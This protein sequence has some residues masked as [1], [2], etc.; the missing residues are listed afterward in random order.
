MCKQTK[1]TKRQILSI[2]TTTITTTNNITTPTTNLHDH[3]ISQDKD[4]PPP[5]PKKFLT[6]LKSSGCS[7]CFLFS[8]NSKRRER[9]KERDNKK[10]SRENAKIWDR[11]KRI[12]LI[13]LLVCFFLNPKNGDVMRLIRSVVL[14]LF[15]YLFFIFLL[16]FRRVRRDE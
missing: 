8:R 10:E 14:A 1:K 4:A 12:L 5:P 15:A 13:F 9:K 11:R 7:F 16:L 3:P 2:A 6:T